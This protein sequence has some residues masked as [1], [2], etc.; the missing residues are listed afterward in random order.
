MIILANRMTVIGICFFVE[1][2][3]ILAGTSCLEHEEGGGVTQSSSV[4]TV[5]GHSTAPGTVS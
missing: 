4:Y 3:G 1:V 2:Y 5:N